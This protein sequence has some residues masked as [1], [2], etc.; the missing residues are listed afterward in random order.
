MARGVPVKQIATADGGEVTVTT[1]YD[2]LMAQY[3]VP[4][5]LDGD[6][7]QSYDEDL[8]YTPAWSEKYTGIGQRRVGSLRAGVGP[9]GRIH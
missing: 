4:R 2:L 7:P 3:G 9:H 6:Y 1:V 8:P 5:G